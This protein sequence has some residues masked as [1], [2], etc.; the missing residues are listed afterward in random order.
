MK[1][2]ER[3]DRKLDKA[4]LFY[5][6][7][8]KIAPAM[9]KLLFLIG[10]LPLCLISC[11]PFSN[12]HSSEVQNQTGYYPI[13]PFDYGH[14]IEIVSEGT[15]LT[16]PLS[17]A[18]KEEKLAFLR[19]D[20][21]LLSIWQKDNEGEVSLGSAAVSSRN[22]S[23]RI[24][25]DYSKHRTIMQ[26]KL[27]KGRIGVGL[28]LV[29]KITTSRN[30]LNLGDF[31]ALGA[32]AELN[33]LHGTLSIEVIGIQSRDISSLIPLPSEL[34]QT[35]MQNAM[36]ALS[37]IKSRIHDEDTRL[38]PQVIG[39]YPA[40]DTEAGRNKLIEALGSRETREELGAPV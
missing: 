35:T 40:Y 12:M 13:D 14:E 38:Y 37:T 19:N 25:M 33:H 3:T 6:P 32:A 11:Q 8:T 29:A 16:R 21:V 26:G 7:T 28:R 30:N 1:L 5:R 39:I 18:T 10:I 36:Q 17:L 20:N 24:V 2:D 9:K 34:N 15:I 4:L 27:G 23:Y 31:F 22:K